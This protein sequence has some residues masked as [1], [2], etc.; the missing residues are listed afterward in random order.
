MDSAPLSDPLAD[1]LAI[2]NARSVIARGYTAG[3]AWAV[4]FPAPGMLKIHAA[5]SGESRLDLDGVDGTVHLGPGDVVVFD[6]SRPFTFSGGPP[7]PALDA[8]EVFAAEDPMVRIGEGVDHIAVGG[9]MELNSAAGDL[10]LDALPPVV[11]IRDTSEEAPVLHWL[12][13]ELF[14][15]VNSDRPG[16]RTAAGHLSQLLFVHALR[17]HLADVDAHPVG[18][19]RALADERIAPALRLIHSSPGHPWQLAELARAATMSRTTFAARFKATA[20]V[21]PLTYLTN[22]RMHLAKHT[23]REQQTS[24]STLAGTLGYASESAFSNAFKRTTGLA[25][26]RYRVTA[27]AKSTVD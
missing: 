26:N 1:A 21:P 11:H 12:L 22:W 24:V 7:A 27:R 5:V 4:R 18:W 15:E 9:H 19:L 8:Y 20:G 6:G 2:T 14:R 13:H 3:G 23:L 17:A 10:L 16:A 25:P